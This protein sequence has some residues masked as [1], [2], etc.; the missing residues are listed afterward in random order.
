MT[1]MYMWKAP[2]SVKGQLS[3]R[4][5]VLDIASLP[6]DILEK[7]KKDLT[8]TPTFDISLGQF[9]KKIKMYVENKDKTKI[10]IPRFYAIEHFETQDNFGIVQKRP[11]MVFVGKLRKENGQDVAVEAVMAELGTVG[12]GVLCMMA[13]GG[14]TSCAIN[15]ACR[16]KVKTLVLVHKSFLADQWVERIRMFCPTASI[17][18]I[19]GKV[20]DVEDKDF[21]IG[22]VQSL[23]MKTYDPSVFDGIGMTVF[24]E[25][26][27]Y[28][29]KII[30]EDGPMFIGLLFNNWEKGLALPRVLSFNETTKK[31]EYNEITYAWR[32]ENADLVQISFSKSNIKCTENHRV[33]TPDGYIYAKDVRPGDLLQSNYKDGLSECMVARSLNPDQFQILL[34]SFLGDGTIR[35][36]PSMRYILRVIHGEKQKDYCEWKA[37]MFGCKISRLD[38]NGYSQGVGYYFATKVIDLTKDLRV[39]R[40]KTNCPQWVLNNLD[41]KGLAIWWMDDGSL[42]R[43]SIAGY[44]STCSFD[45]DSHIRIVHKLGSMGIKSCYREY[46]KEKKY[47][48]IYFNEDGICSLLKLITPYMH[49]NLEYKFTN[50]LLATRQKQYY[51]GDIYSQYDRLSNI[52]PM[53]LKEERIFHTRGRGDF[54]WKYCKKCSRFEF[55]SKVHKVWHCRSHVLQVKLDYSPKEPPPIDIMY[56]TWNTSFLEYGTVRVHDVKR[57]RNI[58]HLNRVY[59]IEVRNNHN[60][61]CSGQAGVGPIVHNCHHA[62]AE[63][64][65]Q[66]LFKVSSKYMLGLTA[67]PERKDGLTRVL[68]WL[69]GRIVFQSERTDSKTTSVR[70]MYYMCDE[71][72]QPPPENRMGKISMATVTTLVSEIRERTDMIAALAIDLATR[73]NRKV[74]VLTDRR[75]QCKDLLEEIGKTF[76]SVGLY[77]GSMKQGD[78]E[79]SNGKRIIISTYQMTKE[80]YDNPAL[81]TLIMASSISDVNQAIGRIQRET[82]GKRND[83]LVIDIVDKYCVFFAQYRKRCQFYKKSGFTM[84]HIAHDPPPKQEY[85]FLDD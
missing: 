75:Q 68:Y 13:G 66:T 69:F 25:C 70:T 45:E 60:F 20:I 77:I 39:P 36:L 33:L 32:K 22:M 4:G 71:Y 29:Q 7:V 52:N 59:D 58:S 37:S 56:H 40:T 50:D 19:Q 43:V 24:D 63:V 67:T 18:R 5:C 21:V 44:L 38:T 84:D 34:G 64:F 76:D 85:A 81:D 12:G 9:P 3:R 15:V 41:A 51:L 6:T 82:P 57:V 10:A 26:F 80:G 42:S 83:P 17:G 79:E 46:G 53:W 23:S 1:G 62:C 72:K 28:N 8:V 78:L 35:I 27:P 47:F 48:S 61:I 14:K 31:T 54:Y 30:T 49:S 74:L 55:H 11:D 65:S 73:E 2:V 16:L